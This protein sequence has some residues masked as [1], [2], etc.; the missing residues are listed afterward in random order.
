[1]GKCTSGR[2][3]TNRFKKIQNFWERPLY[4]MSEYAF[5]WCHRFPSEHQACAFLRYADSLY[6]T[7]VPYKM[8]YVVFECILVSVSTSDS[9]FSLFGKKYSSNYSNTWQSFDTK[10]RITSLLIF[11]CEGTKDPQYAS[12]SGEFQN[13][14]YKY[15]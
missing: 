9:I 13:I 7:D 6:T 8:H 4:E 10:L 2:K 15:I 1:M 3:A 5:K 11:W 12:S 14:K